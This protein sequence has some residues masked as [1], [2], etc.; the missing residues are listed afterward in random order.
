MTASTRF[1]FNKDG[2]YL[3]DKGFFIPLADYYLLAI[4]NSKVTWFILKR[5]CSVLG[6]QESGGR[7]ELRSVFLVN[8]PIRIITDITSPQ[9]LS[10]L[11]EETKSLYS[12]F[13]QGFDREP[14]LQFV[15]HRLNIEP[16]HADVVRD[17]LAFLAE[18]M[19]TMNVMK[20]N[21][22]QTLLNFIEGETGARVDEMSNKTKIREYY[23]YDFSVFI[24]ILGSG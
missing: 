14:I 9:Q 11:I 5:I 17:L 13:I 21:E 12:S 8:L 4:L 2:F 22:I 23:A 19:T 10:H 24:D 6:D 7:L 18:Q 3:N 20:N 15:D 1:T 16:P